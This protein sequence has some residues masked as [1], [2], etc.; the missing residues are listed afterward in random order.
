MNST[1]TN[2]TESATEEKPART[3]ASEKMREA[4]DAGLSCF[5]CDNQ[6][7]PDARLLPRGADGKP[8]NGPFFTAPP[9]EEMIGDWMQ[10]GVVGYG[11][12]GGR[13]SGGLLAIDFEAW[14]AYESW[15]GTVGAL[16]DTLLIQKT[17][18]GGVHVI[19]RIEVAGEFPYR[20]DKL[21]WEPNETEPS[22]RTVLIETRA[23]GG[24]IMGPGSVHP[25][26]R[27]YQ[28]IQGSLDELPTIP[29]AHADA[30]LA[31]ARKLDQ[32]PLTR[33]QRERMGKSKERKEISRAANNGSAS[34]IDEYNR[35]FSVR[36]ILREHGYTE[37]GRDRMLRPGAEPDSQPG[38]VFFERG[39]LE[40]CYCHS[41]NDPLGDGH[42]HTAFSAFCN[43]DHAGDCGASVKAAAATLGL[44]RTPAPQT[45]NGLPGTSDA[46]ILPT[47]T[48]ARELCKGSP[49]MNP[50]V[51]HGLLREREIGNAVSI[52]KAGKSW[53]MNQLAVAV[54]S[55]AIFLG[56]FQTERGNVLIVDNELHKSTLANRLP[57]VA[58]GMGV[59]WEEIADH[60]FVESLRGRLRDIHALAPY[61]NAIKPGKFSLIILD[62]LYRL[63]PIGCD[64]N[65]NADMAAVYNS[66]DRYAQHV[67]AA[68]FIVHHGSKGNQS[69]KSVVD[70]GA[71]AGSQSR[72][73]DTHFVLRPHDE[74]NAVV[75]DAAVRS[76][77]P[78]QPFCLRWAF[79]IWTLADD[80]DPTQLRESKRKKAAIAE[81]PPDPWTT[82]R[83][84]AAFIVAEPKT[85]AGICADA[86]GPDLSE[87]K[88]KRLLR[89]SVD[90]GLAY[91]WEFTDRKK[92][93]RFATVEQPVTAIGGVK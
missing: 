14:A 21:A 54:A 11:I 24:Y 51:I 76:F 80:L 2:S 6:K 55:G 82:G 38:V 62:A 83:F 71:G 16:A 66:L 36:E 75:V 33:Q 65:S 41:S 8:T 79:P 29:Q 53:L 68:I 81:P 3:A 37:A 17:P 61:F 43:L 1:I 73:A 85:E 47:F 60:I 22:G 20:N 69:G 46:P 52:S 30:L 18:G 9:T 92:P 89:A 63:L 91:R 40:V 5:P 35:R 28:I 84:A 45:D 74:D 27:Y 58:A 57:K 90:E 49:A 87:R 26:G 77:P 42:C 48:S 12:A 64:E 50:P 88:A 4:Y 78:I 32:C 19:F 93:H 25:N 7:R 10:Q 31:A 59:P 70:V 44:Q 13:A 39:G 34:V 67:G 72:A 15:R 56:K 86:V 23:A